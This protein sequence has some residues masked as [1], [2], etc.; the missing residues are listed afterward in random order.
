MALAA[1]HFQSEVVVLAVADSAERNLP[2]VAHSVEDLAVRERDVVVAHRPA[3]EAR[4]ETHSRDLTG[5][6]GTRGCPEAALGLMARECESP[7]SVEIPP[8]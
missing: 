5:A 6:C 4:P 1:G 2:L 8:P 3:F 7:P